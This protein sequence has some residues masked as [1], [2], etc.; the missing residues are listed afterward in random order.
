MAHSYPSDIS[1]EQ[2]ALVA[3]FLESARRRTKP[4]TVDLYDVF[5][6]VLYVLKSGCQWR[7]LPKDFPNWRTCYKYFQQ[8]SEKPHPE[9][10]SLL[11]EVLK[12]AGWRGP[13]QQWSAR[14]NQL[15]YCGC[16]KREEYRQRRKQRL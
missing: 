2:F 4:R 9:A 7:M 13:T 10:A 15:L 3:P 8:W 14:K 11:E 5:C 16:S 6:G 1:R 12:K